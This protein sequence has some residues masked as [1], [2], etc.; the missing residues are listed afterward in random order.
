MKSLTLFLIICASFFGYSQSAIVWSPPV[1]VTGSTNAHRPRIDVLADNTPVLIWA[2]FTGTSNKDYFFSKWDGTAFLSPVILND[3]NVLSYDWGG[4]DIVADGNTLYTVYKTGDVTSGKVFIRRSV[5]GGLTWEP[6]IQ[7]EQAN[8]LA[9]YPSVEAYDGNMVLVTYMTHGSGGSNPQYIVRRSTDGGQTFSA[10]AASVSADFGE[11]ACYC[12]PPAI[13]GNSDY[14]VM[15]FRNDE[16][17]IRDMKAGVSTN[18]GMSF[19][20]QISLD[21]HSWWFA[22][23]PATGG[24]LVLNGSQLYSTYMSKGIGDEMIYLVA[25]DLSDS[26]IYTELQAAELGTTMTMNHPH[27]SNYGDSVLLVW[28]HTDQGETDIW[29]NFSTAGMSNWQSTNAASVF[30]LNGIQTKPD[31]V[32]G[33]DGSIHLVYHD[34]ELDKIMY[35]KGSWSSVG[36]DKIGLET[37]QVH[38]NPVREV[39]TI[40]GIDNSQAYSVLNAQGRLVLN[41]SG[42]EVNVQELTPGIYFIQFEGFQQQKFVV[43]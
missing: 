15:S 1:E 16:N 43:K 8:E 2:Q 23:C 3:A 39:L 7:V 10:T 38:P 37:I 20:T 9:M 14:Q 42:N 22:S 24:D 29:Y 32:I 11:E 30:E 21:D 6:K 19:D 33:T 34:A 17:N 13:V 18:G 35:T 26:I 36:V 5:D 41:G 4:T 31:V 12:C 27:L 40:D 28:E 25:D